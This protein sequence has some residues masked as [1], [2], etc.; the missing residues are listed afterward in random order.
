MKWA[1]SNVKH[2]FNLTKL[3]PTAPSLTQLYNAD[4]KLCTCTFIVFVI[5]SKKNNVMFIGKKENIILPTI[6]QNITPKNI[7]F[8][9]DL[10]MYSIPPQNKQKLYLNDQNFQRHC[11]GV[12]KHIF[13]QPLSNRWNT[14]IQ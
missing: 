5:N 14:N 9:F 11:E 4:P 6:H 10:P 7:T 1:T 13:H 3:S 8:Q 12:F 2:Q